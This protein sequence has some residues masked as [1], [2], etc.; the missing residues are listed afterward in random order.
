MENEI[1]VIL[2][3]KILNSEE[4]RMLCLD[5]CLNMIEASRKKPK[6]IQVI[7]YDEQ[8]REIKFCRKAFNPIRMRK[9]LVELDE[10]IGLD[11]YFDDIV[12][13]EV[14]IGTI[15]EVKEGKALYAKY[16][17]SNSI[18]VLQNK[19]ELEVSSN[20]WCTDMITDIIIGGEYGR[21]HFLFREV[22]LYVG[23]EKLKDAFFVKVADLLAFIKEQ[24]FT[25]I[26]LIG[27]NKK[28]VSIKRLNKLKY[29]MIGTSE[30]V[31]LLFAGA[32]E[33]KYKPI[34][35]KMVKSYRKEA[36]EAGLYEVKYK[37]Q[38]IKVEVL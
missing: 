1:K 10:I 27:S 36:L 9:F 5:T 16:A 21:S 17:P 23:R 19:I 2:K 33:L 28:K 22:K 18:L 32:E 31:E 38:K 4:G 30:A 11:F 25:K 37:D 7:V 8:E 3:K 24:H 15:N 14:N 35:Q 20:I 12:T 34:D 13:M 29:D 6:T 26:V